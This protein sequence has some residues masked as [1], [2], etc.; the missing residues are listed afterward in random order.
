MSKI[1]TLCAAAIAVGAGTLAHAAIITGGGAT[2]IIAAPASTALGALESNTQAH[3]FNE[4]T[5]F[6]LASGL[7][8]NA[9]VPGVYTSNG[10]LTPGVIP[11]GTVI[12]SHYLYTDPV[13]GATSAY[14]GF[15]EF[16]ATVI[17][18]IVLRADLNSS[19]FLG[20]LGTTYADNEA[21]GLELSQ[22]E[23]F[24][25]TLSGN[26]INYRFA[27][28]TATDDIRVITLVPA[29]GAV[30][31]AGMGGLLAMRRRRA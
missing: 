11:A 27:T 14:E 2:S 20:A 5:N 19:D 15:I 9:T 16:D 28:S 4:V 3:A 30:A 18:I 10:S 31:L 7:F 24:T 22:A 13:A 8:V 23:R 26:R 17:G 12:N 6:T 1:R 21:R 29:P 25:L